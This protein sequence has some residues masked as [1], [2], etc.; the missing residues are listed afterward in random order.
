[1]YLTR[2]ILRHIFDEE[3]YSQ[4]E[5]LV[6]QNKVQQFDFTSEDDD[7]IGECTVEDLD[8]SGNRYDVRVH[9]MGDR[10][11]SRCSC[12]TFAYTRRCAHLAAA[13]LAYLNTLKPQSDPSAENMLR[14][15]VRRRNPVDSHESPASLEPKIFL[16]PPKNGEYPYLALR[17]GRDKMYV[18]KNIQTFVKNVYTGATESYGKNLT[19]DHSIENFDEKSQKLIRILLNEYPEIWDPKKSGDAWEYY[20]SSNY[21]HGS[22]NNA[23]RLTGDA[24]DRFF[25]LYKNQ[26][27]QSEWGESVAFQE[28]DP[29]IKVCLEREGEHLVKIRVVLPEECVFFGSANTL[30]AM[31]RYALFRCSEEFINQVYPLFSDGQLQKIL[32]AEDVPT[33]CSCVLP[34]IAGRVEIEDEQGILQEYMPDECVAC[35]Y[36]D[37]ED[38]VLTLKLKFRYGESEIPEN[39]PVADTPGIKRDIVMEEEAVSVAK[40]YFALEPE[41]YSLS[42]D[43][44]VFTFLTEDLPRFSSYGEVYVSER[45]KNR[46]IPSS[47]AA[48]GISVSEG[49]LIL[50]LDTGEFPPEELEELYQSLLRRRKYHRLKDGR[51]LELNGSAYETLAEMSHMLQLPA[52]DLKKGKLT[53]PAFRGLYLDTLLNGNEDLKISRD[54]QFRAMV[55]NFKSIEEG[56]YVVPPELESVLRPYQKVGFQWLKTLESSNFGGILADE[57]GLGKTVEVIAYLLTVDRSKN[58]GPCLVVCPASLILNWG[59]E[60]QRFSPHLQ[61]SLIYGAASERKTI[62]ENDWDKDVWVTSYELLRQDIDQYRD[63][64]FYCCILDE[65]QHVKNQ[66]TLAS[67]AVKNIQCRQR[68]VLTGTPVENRLSELWNLFD[69]LMPGYLF[70]HSAFVEKLEKPIVKSKNDD[71]MKQLQRLVQPF[72]LRRLKKDVLKELPDKLEY[73]HRIP[74][75]ENERKV[76][77]AAVNA[78]RNMLAAGQGKL[79]ILAAL[80]QLRQIC[81]DADLCFE[82]YHG[83]TSKLDA[84]IELCSGMVQNGHQI[85]LF[86]Q[87]TSML[88]R[89][90][91]RLD[92][93][94]ISNFTLR[95]ST[96]KKK[97]AELVKAFNEGGAS[98]FLISLKAGGTGLNLTAADVVIHYDPWWNQA[99]QDQA[100]DRAHR[101]GQREHVQVYKLIMQDTIEE[102]ILELQEKK[103]SLMEALSADSEGGILNMSKEEL[104][105]LLD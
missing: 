48:V 73:V 71:A 55:R 99:A 61:V 92:E 26:E 8:E 63:R 14:S 102:R 4:G 21:N 51:Y 11:Y 100:T 84:C 79:Q 72:M 64:V 18:V 62:I 30:Y 35:F 59:D 37:I 56:D 90:Q 98:V 86:S 36:F 67:K 89:I 75:S 68:Y 74:M 6:K 78:T 27:L 91:A 7:V 101:I 104:L 44:E 46:R 20:L 39:T 15:Y 60:F 94:H 103:A 29:K 93:V 88:E 96:P 42:G 5:E 32:V 13:L 83:E 40:Q 45:L 95:G 47:G 53:V 25:D 23:I 70:S 82:N 17:V 81:C 16:F 77:F 31:Q 10:I 38:D 33:F 66:G 28:E 69:F 65:A 87:F 19:L 34:A 50:K 85:L 54:R 9:I 76:Y 12:F 57:M 3:Q 22:R 43:D 1:M 2:E 52:K 49:M 58:Q 41:G 24:F 80:T 105:A 97:R